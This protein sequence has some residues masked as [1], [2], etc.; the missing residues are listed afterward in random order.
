MQAGAPWPG[1]KEQKIVK[2]AVGGQKEPN[3]ALTISGSLRKNEN[4]SHLGL[5]RNTPTQARWGVSAAK[6]KMHAHLGFAD[7]KKGALAER[8]SITAH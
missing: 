8:S 3:S 6:T 1:N 4:A 2:A 5:K 7:A